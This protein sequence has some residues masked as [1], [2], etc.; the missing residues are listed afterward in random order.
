MTIY[1]ILFLSALLSTKGNIV[2][3]QEEKNLIMTYD[4]SGRVTQR[5]IQVM[6]GGRI[7]QF[8]M[9]KDSIQFDFRIFPNPTSQAVNIDGPLPESITS[10]EL[11]LMNVNGQVLKKDVYFGKLKSVTV[12]DLNPG[13]YILEVRYSKT[14]ISSYKIIISN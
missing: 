14:K 11:S 8:D 4:E 9:P 5:N 13:L 12:S 7:G 6:F 1:R 10:A 2:F 3:A